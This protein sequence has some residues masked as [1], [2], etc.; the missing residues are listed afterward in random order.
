MHK[1]FLPGAG[2]GTRLLPVTRLLPKPLVPLYHRPLVV[3]AIDACRA[4]GIIKF[5]V[6]THHLPQAWANAFPASD[7]CPWRGEN[8]QPAWQARHAACPVAFFHEPILL[9]TG[10]G[11]R[12]VREWIGRDSVLVHNADIFSTIPLRLF[13]EAHI[14]SGHPASLLLRSKGPALHVATDP[15]GTRVTDIRRRLGRAEGTRQFTGI[16]CAGPELL[17]HLPPGEPASVIPAFLRLADEGRLGAVVIDEGVW[18]D[19]GDPATLLAAHLVP[20]LDPGVP[21][22]HPQ[23]RIDPAAR[24]DPAT[25]VGPGARL[26]PTCKLE[27]CVVFPDAVVPPGCHDHALILPD[28]NVLRPVP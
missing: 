5:A 11:L 9:D 25:W 21:R 12:N 19:L 10:G 20:P 26:G 4:A 14:A 17:E 18:L 3:H 1:A 8:G 28:G 27:Q 16:Y 22:H 2:L 15:S 24:V 6:N 13:I 7:P 23:A